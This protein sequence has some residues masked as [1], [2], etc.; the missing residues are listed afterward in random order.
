MTFR[1]GD[2]L[3]I[4]CDPSVGVEP[5]KTRPCVVVSNDRANGD[6]D[7]PSVTVVQTRRYSKQDAWRPYLVDL[8]S[9][10]SPLKDERFA[11]CSQV[12]TYDR[13]RIARH[14][15]R[16]SLEGIIDIDRALKLHLSL[17]EELLEVHERQLEYGARRGAARE[18]ASP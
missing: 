5:T 12:M 15:G 18:R 2:I 9:P 4:R 16:V 11:N 6:A 17:D 3:W 14:E 13:V 8:R 7:W 1:R 10:R